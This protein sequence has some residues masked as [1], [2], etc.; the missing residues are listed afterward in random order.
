MFTIIGGDGREYG[1]TTEA[2]VREW[3]ADGR[4]NLQTRARRSEE[5]TWRTLADFREFSG[6]P[7][8]SPAL[9]L[10]PPTVPIV[11]V[12]VEPA[13]PLSGDS[14]TIAADL[15]ARA[16]PLDVFDCIAK[17]WNLW[18]VNFLPLVGVTF[19][20]LAVQFIARMLPVLGLF[21]SIFLNGV[22]AGGLYFYYLGKIRA[23]PRAIG[24]A[25]SGFNRALAPLMMA[26]LIVFAITGA[27]MMLLAGHVVMS[28]VPFLLHPENG[29]PPLPTGI[30]LVG[31]MAAMALMLYLS[32]SW[33]FA[34]A[35]IIDQG[36]SPWTALEV[37]RRV[38]SHQ[39]FRVFFVL[40][41]GGFVAMLGIVGLFFGIIF[42][43]PILYASIM[44]AYEM[45]CRPPPT[46]NR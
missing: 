27:I 19:V 3:I 7:A 11:P 10:L 30:A 1:P 4:A 14:R 41:C 21:A 8:S 20:V 5:D 39:W 12:A 28:L 32:V 29:L 22:F 40:L 34:F 31:V 23:Q 33:T 2:R 44:F 37:S 16:A 17:G 6:A 25:F 9:P 42:T 46:G 35:L 18:I 24:D 15:I 13:E 36:L 43:I 45:L 38:V 26:S